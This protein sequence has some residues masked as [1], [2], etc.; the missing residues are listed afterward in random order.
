MATGIT[1]DTQIDVSCPT[2][3]QAMTV[4]SNAAEFRSSAAVVMESFLTAF[5]L[6]AVTCSPL[7]VGSQDGVIVRSVSIYV[8]C[9]SVLVFIVNVGLGGSVVGPSRSCCNG[10]RCQGGVVFWRW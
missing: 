2:Q 1:K 3:G 7:P 5:M 8:M 6:S 10:S 4:R 9:T